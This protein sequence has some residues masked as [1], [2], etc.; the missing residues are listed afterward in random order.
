MQNAAR[1][2]CEAL[3]GWEWLVQQCKCS[4][5]KRRPQQV[6]EDGIS[7][8]RIVDRLFNRTS[9]NVVKLVVI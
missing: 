7:K 8:R 2:D 6:S 4:V 5:F 1:F 3:D 9:K